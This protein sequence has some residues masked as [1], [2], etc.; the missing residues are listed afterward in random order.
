[1]AGTRGCLRAYVRAFERERERKQSYAPCA[2]TRRRRGRSTVGAALSRSRI[3]DMA[4][5][6]SRAAGQRSAAADADRRG[7]HAHVV[8]AQ[9]GLPVD[10]VRARDVEQVRV[11]LGRGRRGRGER[12]DDLRAAGAVRCA[13]RGGRGRRTLR[14]T[15]WSRFAAAAWRNSAPRATPSMSRTASRSDER[16]R[17][18]G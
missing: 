9:L 14:D 15:S 8:G 1:M 11:E 18:S 7:G 4:R 6:L 10:A 2:Q 17:G 3:S 5:R 12:T 16:G 13:R